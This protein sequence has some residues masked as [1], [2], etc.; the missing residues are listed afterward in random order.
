MIHF[1]DCLHKT[2]ENLF[3]VVVYPGIR[4]AHTRAVQGNPCTPFQLEI[5][6]L[7]ASYRRSNQIAHVNGLTLSMSP[8][9]L[10]IIPKM[11]M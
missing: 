5:K 11:L 10:N 4:K 9:M 1:E 2:A 7:N 3:A 6:E 8:H